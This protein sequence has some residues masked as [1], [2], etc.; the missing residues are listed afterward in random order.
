VCPVQPEIADGESAELGV[1]RKCRTIERRS[2]RP[3]LALSM[4]ARPR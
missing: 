1:A 3:Y 2:V 4:G